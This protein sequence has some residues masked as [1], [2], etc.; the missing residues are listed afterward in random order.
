MS[1]GAYYVIEVETDP[2]L[3]ALDEL[4][5]ALSDNAARIESTIARAAHMR[6]GARGRALLP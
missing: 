2:V 5:R 4:V 3:E 6:A 1:V